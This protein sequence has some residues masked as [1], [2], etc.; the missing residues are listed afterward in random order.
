VFGATSYRNSAF[1]TSAIRPQEQELK[2]Y[3]FPLYT[4]NSA[5]QP[6]AKQMNRRSGQIKSI[7]KASSNF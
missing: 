4:R 2:K 3:F 1:L 5:Q 7:W 6:P